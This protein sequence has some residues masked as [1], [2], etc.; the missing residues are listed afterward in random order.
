MSGPCSDWLTGGDVM[1]C[2]GV[3]DCDN[4][5]LFDQA[6]AEA[7]GLLF[8]L[9]A[10]QFAGLC[11]RVVRPCR[12]RCGCDFQVLSRGYVV[13]PAW[14]WW[15]SSWWYQGIPCGC[16]PLSTVR[17]AGHPV[18]EIL[19]VKID[20][21]VVDPLTYRL[22]RKRNLVRVRDPAAPDV[23]LRWP[24]CQM[25]DLDD[26]E[27]GTFSVTYTYGKEPPLAAVNAA[28]E[29]ACELYKSCSG[30]ACALPRGVTRT[31]R[32]GVTVEKPAFVTWG[33]QTGK[34]R[35]LPRGW[36]TGLPVTDAFLNSMNPS[37]LMRQPVFWSAAPALQYPLPVDTAS[38]S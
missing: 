14:Y 10:R 2:C 11:E 16:R 32:Q 21:A 3:E 22:D 5:S 36:R 6:A 28:A 27:P 37:G 35:G 26:T 23:M 24:A 34:S 31:T 7:Q 12:T 19:E 8:E 9:S 29:L 15:Q 13:A 38:S 4:P 1:A 25:M 17:L 33:F 20:G 18:Q 30:Q